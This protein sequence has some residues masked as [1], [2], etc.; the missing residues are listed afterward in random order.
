MFLS[1]QLLNL[2]G[3]PQLLLAI[4]LTVSSLAI[5]QTEGQRTV[6]FGSLTIPVKGRQMSPRKAIDDTRAG[7]SLLNTFPFNARNNG[8]QQNHAHANHAHDHH[9][10]HDHH[11]HQ[12]RPQARQQHHQQHDSRASRQGQN[13][14]VALNIGAIAAAGE[15]CIDKVIMTEETQYDDV[16]ECKHSYTK[17][18]FDTYKTDYEPQQEEECVE[19]FKRSCFIEYKTQAFKETVKFC[20]QPLVKNCNIQGPEEC[21]TEYQSVC[22]TR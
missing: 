22:S 10:D 1:F 16:I 15:R 9:D 8:A 20:F 7:K 4:F 2:S 21:S 19:N 14:N 17:R 13:D 18:C 5:S 12:A 3:S 11:H 6:Q